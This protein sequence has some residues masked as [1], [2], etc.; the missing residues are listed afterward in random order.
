MYKILLLTLLLNEVTGFIK[1]QIKLNNKLIHKVNQFKIINCSSNDNEN[2]QINQ[3][4]YDN[5]FFNQIY[6]FNKNYF[7]ESL[8][9]SFISFIIYSTIVSPL[10][11]F[12]TNFAKVWLQY[13]NY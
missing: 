2:F 8:S 3:D 10:L 4:K 13:P 5:E 12:W 6:D 7:F 11:I 1:N 9:K